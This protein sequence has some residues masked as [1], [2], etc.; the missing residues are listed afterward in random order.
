MR[1]PSRA[2]SRGSSTATTSRLPP[3]QPSEDCTDHHPEPAKIAFPQNV[4]GHDL[5]GGKDVACRTPVAHQ[6]SGLR[7]HLDAQVSERDARAQRIAEEWGHVDG[8]RPVRF[9]RRE[10]AGAAIVQQLV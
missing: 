4:P 9:L 2:G 5:A 7:I 3:S 6:Y 1:A 8:S 10:A